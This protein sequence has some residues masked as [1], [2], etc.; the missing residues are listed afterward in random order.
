MKALRLARSIILI[1]V[2]YAKHENYE[3]E[4]FNLSP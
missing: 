4:L 3:F 1:P 2:R